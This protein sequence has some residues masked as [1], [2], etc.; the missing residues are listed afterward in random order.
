MTYSSLNCSLT[1]SSLDCPL[2]CRYLDS[3]LTCRCLDCPLNVVPWTVLWPVDILDFPLTCSYLDCPL[4]VFIQSTLKDSTSLTS[5]NTRPYHKQ[6]NARL[7]V[8]ILF[9]LQIYW[10]FSSIIKSYAWRWFVCLKQKCDNCRNL[11]W[12]HFTSY[13]LQLICF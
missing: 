3:P 8:L 2:T 12:L 9:I 11:P 10:S 7:Y 6:D 5:V 13:Y 4:T 1:C